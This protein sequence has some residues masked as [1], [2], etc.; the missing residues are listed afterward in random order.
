MGSFVFCSIY[1]SCRVISAQN[2]MG[3]LTVIKF[4]RMGHPLKFEVLY[5]TLHARIL[6]IV[7]VVWSNNFSS[8]SN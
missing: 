2:W 3:N 8:S 4:L 1:F 7:F 6:Q 5:V